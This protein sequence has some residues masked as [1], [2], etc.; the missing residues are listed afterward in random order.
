MFV[1]NLFKKN[2]GIKPFTDEIDSLQNQLEIAQEELGMKGN[3]IASLNRSISDMES[4][5]TKKIEELQKQNERLQRALA[6][7][8]RNEKSLSET[9]DRLREEK[10]ELRDKIDLLLIENTD[11]KS[12]SQ[13]QISLMTEKIQKMAEELALEKQNKDHAMKEGQMLEKDL[14]KTKAKQSQLEILI[15][16]LSAERLRSDEHAAR[17]RSMYNTYSSVEQ[18]AKT[19]FG[20]LSLSN[21]SKNGYSW[22]DKILKKGNLCMNHRE[23]L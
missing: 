8:Q 12:S 1:A 7:S 3:L 23:C 17:L 13:F 9:I 15:E 19:I 2:I 11:R 22:K 20:D 14:E 4:L 10:E 5:N 6:N 16:H 21:I 18:L